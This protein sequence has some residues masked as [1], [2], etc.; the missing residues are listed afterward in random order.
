MRCPE[1]CILA[2][3][4]QILAKLSIEKVFFMQQKKLLLGAHMS[5]AGGFQN[6]FIKGQE[7]GCTAISIFTKSNRQ[8]LAKP[9][10]EEQVQIFKESFSAS[11]IQA[12]VAHAAY[13]INIGAANPETHKKSIESLQQELERTTQLGIPLVFHPGSYTNETIEICLEK[14]IAG[15]NTIFAAVPGNSMLLIES[16][17]GQG[18][19]VGF[20]IEQLATLFQGLKSTNR[21]GFCID[22]CH[23][24]AAGYD[25]STKTGY[26]QFFDEFDRQVGIE[27]IHAFHVNDSLK[28][29]GSKID[30]HRHIG[31][32]VMGLEPFKLLMNDERFI[33]IPKILETPVDSYLEYKPDL[34]IL[35]GLLTV[36]HQKLP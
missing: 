23:I 21:I 20:T 34:E 1:V 32:G 18:S 27:H 7:I 11:T 14:I 26:D 10:L 24:F 31:Q 28:H 16:M 22:T 4:V 29:S 2:K 15:C 12:V 36:K 8:W 6:A 25:I 33:A 35:K 5:I 13:L 19:T 3:N 17:A 9:L 30:R